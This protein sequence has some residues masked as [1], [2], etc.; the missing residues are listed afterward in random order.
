MITP[1]GGLNVVERSLTI[2]GGY[3]GRLL[4]DLG[5]N[6][7]RVA[8][9]DT[10]ERPASPGRVSPP[11]AEYLHQGKR[12]TQADVLAAAAAARAGL[13]IVE[14]DDTVEDEL[15]RALS[16][17]ALVATITPWGLAGPWSGTGRPWSELTIQAEAG[18]LS[19]RGDMDRF[20]VRAGGAPGYWLAGANVAATAM[21]RLGGDDRAVIDVSLLDNTTYAANMFTDVAASVRGD[22]PSTPH[23]R[24]RLT[25]SVEPTKDGWVGFNLASS[26]NLEDFLVMIERPD[27]LA[28]P[29]MV[30]YRGRYERRQEWEAAVHAW[31]TRHTTEEIIA[32]ARSF[33]IPCAPVHHGASLLQDPHIE[34]RQFYRPASPSGA[35]VPSTPFL[36]DGVRAGTA[37][38]GM[39]E[40]AWPGAPLDLTG[41]KV[42]ELS[43]WWAGPYVGT[44][45]GTMGADV[46]KV[47]SVQR[48]DGC[49]MTGGM[50]TTAPDWWEYSQF[51][52]G[53]NH[54]KR[55]IT[56]DFTRAEGQEILRSLIE[57][58]DVLVENFASV[59][60]E[61]IGFGWE[62]VHEINPRLVMLRMP[63]FGATGPMSDMVG[64]A[65]TV[66]QYSGM[67]WS[68]GYRDSAPLNPSGM[69]DPVAG[70]N[71]CTAV[72][73]ALWERRR[74]GEG[75]LVE[76][77]LYE[78][79]LTMTSE[80]V[81]EWTVNG[82]L[83]ERDGNHDWRHAPHAVYRC[84][85]QES[86]VVITVLDEEQW[87]S[88]TAATADIGWDRLPE[89]DDLAGRLADQ[90]RLDDLI[91]R[92][93]A[94][95]DAASIV[96]LLVAAGV[97]AGIARDPRFI[98][99]HPQIA[100]QGMFEPVTHPAAG[101]HPVPILPV[102]LD[103]GRSRSRLAPPLV[104][105]HNETVIGDDLGYPPQRLE[106]LE[107]IAIIGKRPVNV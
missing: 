84:A 5:A 66:E 32:V 98:H 18:S 89:F 29:E 52:L 25:P 9:P 90:T 106:E 63:A 17:D 54:N 77:P 102:R 99:E 47:E 40:A 107:Q 28:D 58:A 2:A 105:Q 42:V 26:R 43:S 33:R 75:M 97:P 80:L 87:R 51:F 60:L 21:A 10:D 104:G 70:A 48:I 24:S 62:Q 44:F 19:M 22:D 11:L 37:G 31:T 71:A 45:L 8:G 83:V 12:A 56:V 65:Q 15:L 101:R 64:F 6:V 68:T 94:E 59:V 4:A 30:S 57:Q 76:S 3:A 61:R 55:G 82:R 53:I 72:M 95:R 46:V 91:G 79:A 74:T 88:F 1:L 103:D 27:W 34:S 81:L 38:T 73:G 39:D 78:A 92:W 67:C 16:R 36:Y 14:S 50:V 7:T 93:C 20:P 86:W 85:G 13:V 96:E 100:A 69:A 23:V 49:R 41:L 35:R